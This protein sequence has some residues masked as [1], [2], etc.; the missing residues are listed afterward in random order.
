MLNNQL[1]VSHIV[2]NNYMTARNGILPL[3]QDIE[4]SG[5]FSCISAAYCISPFILP[6]FILMMM[7]AFLR[8]FLLLLLGIGMATA[9][10]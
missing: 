3:S 6:P 1:F 5:F 8:I 10:A 4:L 7:N 2:R 9:R